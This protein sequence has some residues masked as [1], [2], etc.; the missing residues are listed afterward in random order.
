MRTFSIITALLLP[1]GAQAQDRAPILMDATETHI[2]P[3]FAQ[4]ADA[5]ETLATTAQADCAPDSEDLRTAYRA[6]FDSWISA[7]HLRFG[8]TETDDRAFAMA[9]WPDTKGFTPKTLSRHIATEDAAVGSPEAYAETSIAGRGFLALERMLYDPAMAEQ[10]SAAYRCALIRAIATDID[11]NAEAMNTDWQ[12]YAPNLTQPGD[13]SLYRSGDEAMQELFRA[14][15]TGL[16]FT[17]DTRLGRPLGT[18]ERPRPNRAEARRSGRSLR[19]VELSLIALRDLA[20]R[21]SFDHPQIA[22]DLDVAFA[23]AIDRAQALDDPAFAGVDTPQGHIRVEAL[24]QS[25]ND[26]REIASTEL[27][28][29]LGISAGFNSLDGD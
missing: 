16:E 25:I 11:R 23:R 12:T 26:I 8:P 9:F 18:F 14:L 29:T 2:L 10:G 3:R 6:A 22:A 20:A 17:A 24:Q 27:G 21:L 28:P 13:D 5:T 15:T 1:L 4:L 19:H 7:S